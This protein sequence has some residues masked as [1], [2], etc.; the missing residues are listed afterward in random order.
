MSLW[1]TTK[2]VGGFAVGFGVSLA[3]EVIAAGKESK[4]N[5]NLSDEELKK[6]SGYFSNATTIQK[7][8]AKDE[9]KNR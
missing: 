1:N 8:L 2:K 9:L 7:K 6:K 3:K 5:K 4:E